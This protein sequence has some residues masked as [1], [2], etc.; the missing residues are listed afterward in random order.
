MS[1]E[2]VNAV[3]FNGNITFAFGKWFE[4]DDPRY[5]GAEPT[6]VTH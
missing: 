1:G 6:M 4:T 3:A 5:W 2:E